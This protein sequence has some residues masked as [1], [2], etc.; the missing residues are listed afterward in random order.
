MRVHAKAARLFISQSCRMRAGEVRRITISSVTPFLFLKMPQQL[1]RSRMQRM[2]NFSVCASC[3]SLCVIPRTLYGLLCLLLFVCLWFE[4]RLIP[5]SFL[6]PVVCVTTFSVCSACIML[7]SL[8][9]SI[10]SLVILYSLLPLCK[11]P[12]VLDWRD[13]CESML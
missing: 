10:F 9:G 2:I 3:L 13:Q 5:L 7:S 6:W 11:Y 8:S 12:L 4:T 1:S